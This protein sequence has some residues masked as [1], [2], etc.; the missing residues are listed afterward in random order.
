MKFLLNMFLFVC[1]FVFALHTHPRL[2]TF[3]P[4]SAHSPQ[5]CK[6]TISLLTQHSS[7]HLPAALHSLDSSAHSTQFCTLTP[8]LHT[9][10]SSAHSPPAMHTH[11]QHHTLSPAL[12][13]CVRRSGVSSVAQKLLL[14]QGQLCSATFTNFLSRTL[15][16]VT[17]FTSVT[18]ESEKLNSM[19]ILWSI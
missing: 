10:P 3:T 9:H 6:L 17:N 7:A 18:S 11:P 12:H 5:L 15:T 8:A 19:S 13:P 1:L 4:K 14:Y 16:T 2:C